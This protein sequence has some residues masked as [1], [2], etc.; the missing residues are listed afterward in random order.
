[1]RILSKMPKERYGEWYVRKP[2]NN[3]A[4]FAFICDFNSNGFDNLRCGEC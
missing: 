1:M 2:K 3:I 4:S